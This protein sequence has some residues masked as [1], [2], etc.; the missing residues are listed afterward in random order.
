MAT[1]GR[2]AKS[3]V[4]ST[5]KFLDKISRETESNQS[6]LSMVLGGLIVLVVGVLIFN[7]FNKPKSDLGPA[8]Q[9]TATQSD[10]TPDQLP[11]KYTVKE[12]DTL[13]NIA[14]SYYKDGYQYTE[15]AKANN[16]PNP[17]NI[18]KG[19]VLDIPKLDSST[20]MQVAPSSSPSSLPQAAMA[21]NGTGGGNT[22]I[23]GPRIDG[24]SY[25]VT[26]GD[27]LSTIAGRA[28][29]DVYSFQKIADANN[30]TN[31]NLIEPGMVLKIPR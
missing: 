3:K 29:G 13:F 18:E 24:D 17:D 23:W 6:R 21:D 12:G 8:S 1:R 7:Y 30:I 22:T 16:L 19:Q 11:G 14:N 20:T 5:P 10:V 31:P 26:D 4:D 2:P 28:Y 27:W 9:T 15:I 25:T